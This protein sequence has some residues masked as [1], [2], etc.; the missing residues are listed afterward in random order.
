MSSHP[1]D[2]PTAASP[3]SGQRRGAVAVIVRDEKMLIIR[4][5]STVTAPLAYCFPGGGIEAGE[6]EREALVRELNEELSVRVT[7][8]GRLWESV[9]PWGVHLA[10]WGAHLPATEEIVAN[11]TEVES[12][13]W[14][15]VA[16]MGQLD[17]LLQS[18][19]DFLAA[20]AGG[21]FSIG[22]FSG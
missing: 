10:W 16:Q 17:G 13:Q 20:L 14:L 22:G 18:N 1:S 12:F 3:P 15:T 2:E 8:L 5:S 6:S 21:E 11:P 7:P 4:R 19:H 9:T